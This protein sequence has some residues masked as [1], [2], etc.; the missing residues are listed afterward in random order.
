[1][2]FTY[3]E[4]NYLK[5]LLKL[6]LPPDRQVNTN[7]LAHHLSTSAASVTDMLKKL[8]EKGYI[9]YERYKGASLT[10]VGNRVATE[11][12]RKHRLWEVFLVEKLGMNWDEVH[13]IAEELEHIQS[14]ELIDKLDTFLGHPRFDPHGDPI[15]NSKGKYTLRSQRTIAEMSPDEEGSV[16]GVKD[17]SAGFLKHLTEKGIALGKHIVFVQQDPYDQSVSVI[18][19]DEKITLSGKVAQSIYIKAKG[20]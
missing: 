10:E 17:D 3:A 13:E 14:P 5:A 8:S 15:P 20:G 16:V 6:S 12:I 2:S 11:L 7:T 9:S 4:E 19:N 1:M 18:L